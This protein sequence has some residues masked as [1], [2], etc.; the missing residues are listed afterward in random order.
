MQ[1]FSSLSVDELEKHLALCEA[2]LIPLDTGSMPGAAH[3]WREEMRKV[4]A[5]ILERTLLK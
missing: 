1:D 2:C 5:E 4:E 3:V